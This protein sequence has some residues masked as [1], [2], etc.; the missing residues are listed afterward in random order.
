[1]YRA[2][3]PYP[4]RSQRGRGGDAVCQD[5][6]QTAR[7]LLRGSYTGSDEQRLTSAGLV[8]GQA[9]NVILRGQLS[10]HPQ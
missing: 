9:S 2:G 4:E 3:G 6:C 5:S 10:S 8:S 7:Y 1:M